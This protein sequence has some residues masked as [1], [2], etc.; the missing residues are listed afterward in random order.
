MRRFRRARYLK[1]QLPVNDEIILPVYLPDLSSETIATLWQRFDK[2]GAVRIQDLSEARDIFRQIAF[3]DKRFRP[4]R[5]D[6]LIFRQKLTVVAD[7]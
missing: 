5:S 6:H 1:P 4:Y 3:F 2:R 7:Q